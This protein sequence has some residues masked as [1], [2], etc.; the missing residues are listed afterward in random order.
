M[1]GELVR[2]EEVGELV[3]RLSGDQVDSRER[4]RL[5]AQLTAL[6]AGGFRA[7]GARATLS[8]RWLA[9]VVSDIAPHIPVRDLDTLRLHHGGLSGDALAEALVRQASR[10]TAGVGAAGGTLAAVQ[11]AAP[12]TLLIAPI[13]LAAETVA[14]VAV[15]LKLVAELHVLYG[16]APLAPAPQVAAAYVGSWAA[17]RGVDLSQKLGLGVVLGAAARQQLRRRVARRLG[18]NLSTMAPF[19]AGA[20]AGADLNRR[21][22]RA[23]GAA[24]IAEL[25]SS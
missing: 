7:A 2:R 12:P 21:E 3:G 8:G 11:H 25:R 14:V 1:S 10:A 9:D 20:V 24:L 6:L 19:L 15:E 18:R 22:T 5:L 13:Q 4:G 23:L 16:R 17:K